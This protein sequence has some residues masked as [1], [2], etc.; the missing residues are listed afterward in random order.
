MAHDGMACFSNEKHRAPCRSG[1][2]R[3]ERE[4]EARESIAAWFGGV[5]EAAD[6]IMH[7]LPLEPIPCTEKPPGL[8]CSLL[9]QRLFTFDTAFY[10]ADNSYTL[11]RKMLKMYCAIG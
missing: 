7:F 9:I 1:L 11:L 5:G 2:A 6:A 8:F 3:R 10:D 4:A